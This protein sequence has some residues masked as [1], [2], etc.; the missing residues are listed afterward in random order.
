L[1]KISEIV[2]TYKIILS[3]SHPGLERKI[4]KANDNVSAACLPAERSGAQGISLNS[5]HDQEDKTQIN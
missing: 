3:A 1:A 2:F 5:S 4:L